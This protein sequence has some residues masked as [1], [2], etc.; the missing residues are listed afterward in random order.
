MSPKSWAVVPRAAGQAASSEVDTLRYQSERAPNAAAA[1]DELLTVKLRYKQPDGDTSALLSQVARDTAVTL[2]QASEDFRWACAVAGF[3]MLLR[4][5]EHKG[6]ASLERIEALARAAVGS[7][8]HAERHELLTMLDEA[9]ALGIGVAA[10]ASLR[11]AQTTLMA[12]D[13]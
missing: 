13:P 2:E 7:D 4:D 10:H 9:R 12:G 6:E 1:S 11:A 8:P 3:G 5:S